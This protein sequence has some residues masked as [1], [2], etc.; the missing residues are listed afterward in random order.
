MVRLSLVLLGLTV[1]TAAEEGARTAEERQAYAW[2]ASLGYPDV[3]T[4]PFVRVFIGHSRQSDDGTWEPVPDYGFLVADKGEEFTVFTIGLAT[5]TYTKA[6]ADHQRVGYEPVQ[7]QDYV[8]QGLASLPAERDRFTWTDEPFGYRRYSPRLR[9]RLYA[10]AYA[11]ASRGHFELAHAVWSL[12]WDERD[13]RAH[14]GEDRLAAVR[15]EVAAEA[16]R[17]IGLAFADVRRSFATQLAAYRWWQGRFAGLPGAGDVGEEIGI[18]EKM[19]AEEGRE[20]RDVKPCISNWIRDLKH[21]AEGTE[22]HDWGRAGSAARLVGAGFDAVPA[23]LDAL[24]DERF[25]R[26]LLWRHS[27]KGQYRD[28]FA[29]ERVRHHVERVLEEIAARRF[30]SDDEIRRW[31]KEVS[32]KGEQL[33]LVEGTAAG[34]QDSARQGQRL[35]EKYPDVAE[36]AILQGIEAAAVDWHRENLV[37]LL[38]FFPT[39]RTTGFLLQ[40]LTRGPTLES[41]VD[42]AWLLLA[43]GRPEPVPAMIALWRSGDWKKLRSGGFDDE[44]FIQFLCHCGKRAAVVAL[45]RTLSRETKDVRYTVLTALMQG[46]RSSQAWAPLGDRQP[47]RMEPGWESAVEEL[48][49]R[50][51]LDTGQ[52]HALSAQYD[53]LSF[54]DPRLSDVAAIALSRHLPR[55]YRYDRDAPRAE[56]ERQRIRIANMWRAEHGLE[57]LPVPEPPAVEPLLEEVARPLRDAVLAELRGPAL[58]A[59]EK[60]GLPALA[61]VL[62]WLDRIEADHPARE[63]L[64]A[65]SKRLACIVLGYEVSADSAPPDEPLRSK[66]Q[67]L[68][69]KPLS[70]DAFVGVVLHVTRALPEGATG[71]VL[72]AVRERKGGVILKVRLTR[73]HAESDNQGGWDYCVDLTV[74]RRVGTGSWCG[75]ASLEY[76]RTRRCWEDFIEAFTP[77]LDAHPLT[78]FDVTIRV[79]REG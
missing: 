42:A 78:P 24:G 46:P 12:A 47:L 26:S 50:C 41:R 13:T 73:E 74:G 33:V 19:V 63:A 55:K 30:L 75:C 62:K 37:R 58:A 76:G 77:A 4:L 8:R 71:I 2:L 18:L 67:A 53:G 79:V 3:A 29:V 1:L 35:I 57:P 59:V 9:F 21:T 38:A 65:L 51:L 20:R 52:L 70:A 43:R 16:R 5:D 7:L 23:L 61:H 36:A 49:V 32:R 39:A 11:C 72:R 44:H 45:D 64:S 27:W 17:N 48:L 69:G 22:D 34:K 14:A 28:G 25:S 60:H 56:C 31:W 6:G 10:L 66:L 68:V 15:R 54:S 40:D